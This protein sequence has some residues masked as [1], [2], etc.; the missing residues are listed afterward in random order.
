MRLFS[1]IKI[2]FPLGVLAMAASWVLADFVAPNADARKVAVGSLA[3]L[4][5]SLQHAFTAGDDFEAKKE[6]EW[7]DWLA[8]HEEEGQTF[9][10]YLASKP[11]R[12]GEG[13]RNTLYVLP[14]GRFEK[15]TSPDLHVLQRYME[16]Y[17]TP[18]V[19]KVLPAMPDKKVPAV[20]RENSL[21]GSLQWNS[22]EM[23]KWLRTQVPRD[24]Y[25]VIAITMT[26]LY[27]GEGWN[28]VFGQAS[29]KSRVGIFSFARYHPKLSFEAVEGDVDQIALRRASQVL[30]H[31]MGHMFGIKH[32]IHYEC[33]MNGANSLRECDSTPMH[34]CP[35]CLRKLQ[36]AVGFDPT[37][38]YQ[39]LRKFYQK[40]GFGKEAKWTG[41]R[42]NWIEGG[43]L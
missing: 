24:A 15:E 4:E 5:K 41:E 36:R 26:D 7:A 20:T 39:A 34:L 13:G 32:C 43:D 27:P 28:F 21:T 10:Q 33:N 9:S 40:N 31:E 14:L 16:L 35:V 19:V 42:L 8:Q 25:G 12:P 6:P 3:G 22:V 1:Q 29:Y 17:Y 11:N 23:L 2:V 30:T 37:S 18:M 38:R